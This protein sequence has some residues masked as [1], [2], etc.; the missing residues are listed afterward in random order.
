MGAADVDGISYS[1]DGSR[2]HV[3]CGEAP[4][5][6]VDGCDFSTGMRRRAVLVGKVR[7]STDRLDANIWRQPTSVDFRTVVVVVQLGWAV[8]GCFPVERSREAGGAGCARTG[9]C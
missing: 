6:A 7:G 3:I 8:D 2:V 1:G 4:P 5:L 9:S